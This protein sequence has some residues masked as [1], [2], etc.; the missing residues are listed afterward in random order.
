MF[1]QMIDS[2]CY[3]VWLMDR[4]V[5]ETGDTSVLQDDNA[6]SGI[7]DILNVFSDEMNHESKSKYY[8]KR[9]NCPETDTLSNNGMGEP[10]DVTGMIWGGFR[11]SDDACKYGYNIPENIFSLQALSIINRL[12]PDIDGIPGVMSKCTDP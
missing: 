12:Y 11:P 5:K 3:P 1:M 4:Y 8:F 7:H 10:I 2:L 6:I 9:D